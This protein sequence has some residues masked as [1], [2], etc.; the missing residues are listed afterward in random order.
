MSI[1]NR[2]R[3]KVKITIALRFPDQSAF[4]SAYFEEAPILGLGQGAL[5]LIGLLSH[6]Q[7]NMYTINAVVIS[8][9]SMLPRTLTWMDDFLDTTW[10]TNASSRA[11]SRRGSKRESGFGLVNWRKKVDSTQSE[12]SEIAV[13]HSLAVTNEELGIHKWNT[14]HTAI[15]SA[16]GHSI[17]S[18]RSEEQLGY[19]TNTSATQR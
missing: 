1:D 5:S 12:A 6:A 3:R 13:R 15:V 2:Y 7:T 14:S 4:A 9:S 18:G 17:A 16:G 10:I 19:W 11:E 8:T